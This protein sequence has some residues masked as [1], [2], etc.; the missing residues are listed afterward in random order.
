MPGKFYLTS[1]GADT[2]TSD[3]GVS[4]VFAIMSFQGSDVINGF[5]TTS[6]V[7]ANHDFINF[8]GR[9]ISS[10][11]QVQSMMSGSTST[12]I[13]IGSGKTITLSGIAPSQFS[14]SDFVYS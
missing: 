6:A 8:S 13:N 7:G 11:N 14:S 1:T 4:D 5:E 2:L 12:I 9:G 3:A 10:F